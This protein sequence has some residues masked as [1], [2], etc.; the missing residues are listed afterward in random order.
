MDNLAEPISVGGKAILELKQIHILNRLYP[1]PQCGSGAH[2]PSATHNGDQ[3]IQSILLRICCE[4]VR[5]SAPNRFHSELGSMPMSRR[6]ALVE[7]VRNQT[8]GLKTEDIPLTKPEIPKA[9]C[10]ERFIA[11]RLGT[12]SPKTRVKYD[13]IRVIRTTATASSVA[14]GMFTP[15]LT[16]QSTRGSEK[17]SAAKRNQG[18]LTA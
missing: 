1:V 7:T 5:N 14:L 4:I 8:I 3:L 2:M 12:S 15:R 13:R 18:S 6:T 10:S 11:T 9:S 17:L 16:T